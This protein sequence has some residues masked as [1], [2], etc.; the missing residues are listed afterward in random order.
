MFKIKDIKFILVP[1]LEEL[2]DERLHQK[3]NK[4]KD[5]EYIHNF[6]K[7]DDI[8]VKRNTSRRCLQQQIV[9]LKWNL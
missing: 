2:T 6:L 5:S 8:F 7:Y 9:I 1:Q 3:C 4:K